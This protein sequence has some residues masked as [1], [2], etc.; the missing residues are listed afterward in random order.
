MKHPKNSQA[1]NK[2]PVFCRAFL[3]LKIMSESHA[4]LTAKQGKHHN[5]SSGRAGQGR[6]VVVT[7]SS[8]SRVPAVNSPHTMVSR[9]KAHSWGKGRRGTKYWD[10]SNQNFWK[11]FT[12]CHC[13]KLQ[14]RAHH[15]EHSFYSQPSYLLFCVVINMRRLNLFLQG[16]L[17]YVFTSELQVGKI[18]WMTSSFLTQEVRENVS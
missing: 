1:K 3:S 13:R 8:A 14:L 7:P 11:R 12:T 18:N 10:I 16:K 15:N 9:S 4:N 17:V 6:C 2:S 5:A